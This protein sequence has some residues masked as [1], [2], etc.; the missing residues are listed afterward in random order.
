[1]AYQ[2]PG[3]LNN[4]AIL[5]DKTKWYYVTNNRK[6]KGYHTFLKITNQK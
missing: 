3:L 6:D 2:I 1:M 5:V 4:K